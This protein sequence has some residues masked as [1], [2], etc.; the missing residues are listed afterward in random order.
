[1]VLKGLVVCIP[2]LTEIALSSIFKNILLLS[3][4]FSF[5]FASASPDNIKMWKFPDGNFLHNLQGH[6][7]IIN[8]LAVNSDNVLVSGGN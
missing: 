7:T 5:T 6:N 4:F 8:C 3:F 2:F 1:M